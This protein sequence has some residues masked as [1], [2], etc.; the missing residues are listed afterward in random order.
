VACGTI[1]YVAA[2]KT[3]AANSLKLATPTAAFVAQGTTTGAG[4]DYLC[5]TACSVDSGTPVTLAR[6]QAGNGMGVWRAATGETAT[7]SLPTT[8]KSLPTG[9]AYRV[10]LT[11]SLS[12]GPGA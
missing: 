2:G 11:W 5:V 4:A 3:L 6:A 7:L 12:S 8:V 9:E 1:G 10:D